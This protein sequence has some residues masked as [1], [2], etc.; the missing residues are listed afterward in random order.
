MTAVVRLVFVVLGGLAGYQLAIVLRHSDLFRLAS[1]SYGLPV[2]IA[3]I[4]VGVLVGW[5]VGSL[6]ARLLRRAVSAFDELLEAHSGAELLV[7][8]VGLI[9]G[10]GIAAIFSLALNRV[11]IIG[12]Y[13]LV[14]FFLVSGYLM[15]YL[16]A[17]KHVE[18]LRLVGLRQDASQGASPK[19]L[20]SSAIIDGR[21]ADIVKVG[22]L[23]GELLVP[24]FVVEELQR[25][26]DSADAEK[27][28]R[29]RRGLDYV[30]KLQHQS[31]NVRVVDIDYADL[32]EVDA[33]LLRLGGELGA[34]VVTT[35]YTLNKV[36]EI[37]GVHVLNV[38]ELANAVKSA[39]LPGEEIEVKV[40][41]E[42]REQDQGIGYLEDG[43]MIVVEEG[44]A[45]VGSR[46][47]AEVT[48]VL[49][50]PSG[51]MVFARLVR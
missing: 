27:R 6:L 41:R 11:P 30:R 46:V 16:A 39:V 35:D 43:T 20:D 23:E 14:P 18:L 34:D 3:A 1:H 5:L 38:N 12:S 49:Q 8:A 25:L 15:A 4:V 45:M 22:F 48:S 21:A 31:T 28:A 33:K 44:A 36:A 17:R 50:S 19:V 42:G 51:K 13:V 7:G 32:T 26:A 29:G 47:K 2:I 37:Q 24:R 10:L 40:L 9:A